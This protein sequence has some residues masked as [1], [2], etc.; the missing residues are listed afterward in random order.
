MKLRINEQLFIYRIYELELINGVLL[1]SC[2]QGK[3]TVSLNDLKQI[4]L[5]GDEQGFH[6]FILESTKKNLDGN[7]LCHQ[8]GEQF[9][10]MLQKEI[11]LVKELRMDF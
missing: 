8:D 6:H 7:F 11:K 5:D 4:T 10:H 2:S 1:F 9:V 3:M